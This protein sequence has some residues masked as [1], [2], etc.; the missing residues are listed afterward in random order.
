[1]KRPNYAK[2][3]REREAALNAA[4]GSRLKASLASHQERLDRAVAA[5]D[6]GSMRD[7]AKVVADLKAL[8]KASED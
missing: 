7:A 4:G 3:A 2:L 1:M 6:Y 8:I 5:K